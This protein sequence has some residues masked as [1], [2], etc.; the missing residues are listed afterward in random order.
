MDDVFGRWFGESPF[1]QLAGNSAFQP[2]VDLWETPEAYIL[3]A[4]LPGISKDDLD[5]EVTGD[6]IS[7]KGSRKPRVDDKHVIYHV[8]NIGFG[9]FHLA[10]T[11]P[12]H[13][14]A[15]GVKADYRDGILEVTLPKME[16]AKTRSIKIDIDEK[17]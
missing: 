6:T 12:A 16:A 1:G 13:I 9:T 8:Q 15:A 14:D 3:A 4:N 10:Y 2:A 17:P 5:L 7:I 11:L